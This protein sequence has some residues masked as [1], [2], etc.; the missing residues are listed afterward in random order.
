MIRTFTIALGLATALAWAQSSNVVGTLSAIHAENAEVEIKAD[1]GQVTT[2]KLTPET[3]FQRVAPGEKDLRKA[4][5]IA[6]TDIATGDRVLV[7][8]LPGTTSA[9]RIIVM[10]ATDIARRNEADKADWAKR[11]V[12]GVVA[13]KSGNE[14]VVR[15]RSMMTV[16]QA[17]VTLTDKTSIKRYAPDSVKFADARA[18][19]VAQIQVGDQL[20]ARGQKSEDGLKVTAE[21]VV[22]G[23]FLTRAGA[24]TAVDAAA[25]SITVKEV[26]T[27]KPFTV[28]V[29]A[30]STLKMMPN[31]PGMGAGAM[32][33]GGGP[34]GGGPRGGMGG[35]RP[36][37]PPDIGQ[38]LERMPAAKLSDIQAGQ[39]IVVSSTKGAK[40]DEVTAITLLG[41]AEMIVRMA[42]TSSGGGNAA[43]GARGGGGGGMM[44][45]GMMGGMDGF[46]LPGMMP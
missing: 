5:K 46:N 8:F 43:G 35:G 33:G 28:K 44:G 36:G 39:T 27:N 42:T 26:G 6:P 38:M 22:F 7:S 1:G 12:S 34:G 18:S 41:N 17:T 2:A 19:S 37:G 30:D 21:E 11:G 16:T 9:R 45:G 14:V 25:N 20:R 23:T 3:V 24:V 40:N 15:M 29:T 32:M 13:S 31:F 4:E 10:A